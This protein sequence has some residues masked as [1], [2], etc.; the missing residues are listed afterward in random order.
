MLSQLPYRPRQFDPV[1][2]KK[3]CA[4]HGALAVGLHCSRR[5]YHRRPSARRCPV[6][7]EPTVAVL[8][9]WRPALNASTARTDRDVDTVRSARA[10]DGGPRS[11]APELMR[12]A[13][14]RWPI[15]EQAATDGC[16]GDDGA[17]DRRER[18]HH[19]RDRAPEPGVFAPTMT[20]RSLGR[21][22]RRAVRR[23]SLG[24][25]RA[26][27]RG[28][29]HAVRCVQSWWRC[30]GAIIAAGRRRRRQRHPVSNG[31]DRP[32][33]ADRPGSSRYG[34]AQRRSAG[35]VSAAPARLVTRQS[36]N[37]DSDGQTRW[38]STPPQAG[39]PPLARS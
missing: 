5:R 21:S 18:Y 10:A 7:T 3:S 26:A 32:G 35:T 4:H 19:V 33:R 17:D 20:S 12:G 24:A 27:C 13:P 9:A 29:W 15:S 14:A 39:E 38:R 22:R 11:A 34:S 6:Q 31:P 37:R 1:S 2:Y 25:A 36:G 8:A 23:T 16:S 28:R 30:A